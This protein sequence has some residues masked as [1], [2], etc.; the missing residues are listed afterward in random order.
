[1]L[2]GKV[3]VGYVYDIMSEFAEY[4]STCDVKEKQACCFLFACSGCVVCVWS[5]FMLE[6]VDEGPFLSILACVNLR[7]KCR[8]VAVCF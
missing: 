8:G 3:K 6:M 5:A 4:A 7:W 1:M 2:L